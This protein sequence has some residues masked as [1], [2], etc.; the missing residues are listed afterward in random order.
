MAI[1]R[2]I[3]KKINPAKVYGT[4]LSGEGNQGSRFHYWLNS[5]YPLAIVLLLCGIFFYLG[6]ISNQN[7]TRNDAVKV[8]YTTNEISGDPTQ[9]ANINLS[10]EIKTV[11]PTTTPTTLSSTPSKNNIPTDSHVIGSKSG[12]KYY[13][14]WCGTVKRIKPEN[15]VFFNSIAEAKVAGFTPGGNCKGLN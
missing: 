12:R 9:T 11:N 15:Q 14:P 2:E 3:P 4:G 13:F 6:R 10:G 1:I 7:D 5:F 8:V